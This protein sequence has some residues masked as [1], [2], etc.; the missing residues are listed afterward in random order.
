MSAVEIRPSFT[1]SLAGIVGLVPFAID[2]Y[3]SSL[4][5]IGAEFV[6][7][8]WV[9]QLTLTGYLLLLGVGQLIA[10]P[11]TDTV[12]RRTPLL[13]GLGV[14][15]VGSVVAALA[16]TMA[17]LVVARVL[18]GLGGAIAVVVA[19]SSV[20]DRTHGDGATRLYAILLTVTALAPVIAPVAGGFV[21][22]ALG[23][24]AVFWVLAV[25]GVLVFAAATIFLPESLPA[26]RRSPLAL[27]AVI[28]GYGRLFVTRGFVVPLI[29]VAAMF[30]LLFA[31]IGG[32]S[33]VYQ[34]H[35]GVGRSAFGAIFGVTALALLVGALL[36]GRLSSRLGT[37]RL[38][39]VGVAVSFAGTAIALGSVL[40]GGSLWAVAAGMALALLGLGICE[41]ALMSMCMSAVDDGAGRAAAL[42][43]GAQY[44][45][46]AVATVVA[47]AVAA[48]GAGSWI[49]LMLA[50][51]AVALVF[52]VVLARP[53]AADRTAATHRKGYQPA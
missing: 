48:A 4:P 25:L 3:L 33:Y 15:V 8:I 50:F 53:V 47:G 45:F 28:G 27:G 14:F 46:G 12:G 34:G 35:F 13:I 26:G 43:G 30:M 32:A 49:G 23:W 42:L 39:L 37:G 36:A 1:L 7:P 51:A 29:A 40:V 9:T 52:A 18:Q 11:I 24:R 2:M 38:G 22:A 31:Y 10:G 6:A 5:A 17:V 20:R 16:P 21:D 44:I 19:N 41:P